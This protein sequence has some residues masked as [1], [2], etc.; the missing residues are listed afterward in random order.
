MLCCGTITEIVP[1]G[2]NKPT[3]KRRRVRR[4]GVGQ[5][6]AMRKLPGR[7]AIGAA[8][9]FAVFLLGPQERITHD[10]WLDIEKHMSRARVESILG[11]PRVC[12]SG[13]VIKLNEVYHD[14]WP[15]TPDCTLSVWQSDSATITI[16]FDRSD[17][18]VCSAFSY[19]SRP[20]EQWGTSTPCGT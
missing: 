1:F 5:V 3:A 8:V 11:P 9:A 10:N 2:P 19:M 4:Y 17:R 20:M 7:L 12:T 6:F 13:P 15:A 16:A 18:V 14:A